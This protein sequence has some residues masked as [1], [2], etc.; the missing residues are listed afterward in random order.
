[1]NSPR[2]FEQLVSL[3]QQTHEE[4]YVRAVRV[5][6]AHLVVRNWLFGYYIAEFEQLGAD[7][8][9]Y[10]VRLLGNLADR[11]KPLKIKGT[12]ATRLKLYRSF[13]RLFPIGPTASDQL[14]QLPKPSE[15]SPTPSDLL[16][17]QGLQGRQPLAGALIKH[18]PLGW[19]HYVELL[20]L[21]DIAERRFYEIEAAANQ[22]TVRELQRQIA[23]SLYQRLALSR[24]KD[25]IRRLA[26]EGQVV[27][28]AADLIKNPLVLEFLGLED[29]P[30]YSE[31]DLESAII[32]QL[33][34][35]LLELG[36]G[37]LFEARQ[38]RFT[39]D[40][41]HF[42]V[43]LVFYNRLLRCYVLIDLKR[44][45]LTHQDLGQMQMYVNYFDRHVK[46]PEELPTVGIVLCHRKN[47]ALVELTLPQAANI[48]ASKYQLY[49]PSKEE[50]KARLEQ[51]T[52]ELE[53]GEQP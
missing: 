22:W 17:A 2:N 28:K 48:F 18:F 46:L 49:L 20:T 27:E 9:Q 21:D 26:A 33:E 52:S 12:S 25:E 8:A 39:F 30:H 43:D 50:L 19:S 34:T 16:T 40:N 3:C 51:I 47:D 35:F 41:D 32:D 38:K 29:R 23:S 53:G 1:M 15:I 7:R 37:F 36:K 4:L 42:R 31:E 5:V 10:G 11:L 14:G 13:Y 45:K 44:D 6:D 24:D